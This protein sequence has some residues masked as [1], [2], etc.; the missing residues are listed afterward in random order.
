[1]LLTNC[2]RD[3]ARFGQSAELERAGEALL[4]IVAPHP[5]RSL[6]RSTICG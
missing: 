5:G 1:M 3:Q 6:C 2:A 4:F